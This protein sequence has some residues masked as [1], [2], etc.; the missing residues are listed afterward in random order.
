MPLLDDLKREIAGGPKP[1]IVCGAGV[2]KAAN[3]NAPNWRA[4]IDSGIERVVERRP[5]DAAWGARQRQALEGDASEWIGA[6]DQ[7]TDRL[8]GP[9]HGEFR[10]WLKDTLGD[11]VAER[12]E[13]L[14]A[15][16]EVARAGCL[17]STTNYDSILSK[18]LD[19]PVIHWADHPK[20]LEYLNGQRK[21]VL[22]LHGH[23]DEPETV[24]L[25][26]K[27]Y[28][29]QVR[30]ERRNFLQGMV[31]LTRPT[32]FVGC[33]ADGLNDP[34]FARLQDWLE[35]WDDSSP[36]R[37]WL[38]SRPVDAKTDWSLFPIAYGSHDK[39]PDFL[40]DLA[41]AKTST[42]PTTAGAAVGTL[43]PAAEP[44]VRC[45]DWEWPKPDA[46]GREDEIEKVARALVEGRPAVIA[47]GPGMGK[48]T[49]AVAAMYEPEVRARFGRR[50]VFATVEDAPEPRAFLAKLALALGLP[51]T[52]DEASLLRAIENACAV[53]PVAAILDNAETALDPDQSE[54]QRILRLLAQVPNLSLAVTMREIPVRLRADAE[55]L[56]DLAPLRLDAA[57]SAFLAVAGP[58]FEHDRFLDA[59]LESTL[60]G[61]ALSIRIVAA[62]AVGLPSLAGLQERWNEERGA[63]LRQEGA[64]KGR[65]TSVRASVALSLKS[66]RM[67]GQPLA[68]RLLALLA[69]LPAG[70]AENEVKDLL[71]EKGAV[72]KARAIE[73]A[74][75]L[76]QM[77]LVESRVEGR[78]RMLTP[79]RESARLHVPLHLPD[80]ERLLDRFLK[81]AEAGELVGTKDWPRVRE[82]VEAESGNL[83][84]VCDL[85]LRTGIQLSR[86]VR[87]LAGTGNLARLSG[88]GST[89][90]LSRSASDPRIQARPGL[91]AQIC[92]SIGV[93]ALGRSDYATAHERLEHA[94]G[95]VARRQ[96]DLETAWRRS[97][98]ALPLYRKLGNVIGEANSIRRMGGVASRRLDHD[99]A[100]QRFEEALPLF[101]K[102][103]DVLGEA[104]CIFLMT[105]LS[106]R[107]EPEARERFQDALQLYREVGDVLGEA[108]CI[109]DIGQIAL[110]RAD[111]SVARQ[112]FE[113]ALPLYRTIGNLFGEACALIRRG[114]LAQLSDNGAARAHFDEA[115]A[116]L[117]RDPKDLALPGWRAFHAALVTADS[118]TA[119]EK[120]EEAR[121]YW[122]RVGCLDLV[123]RFLDL[124]VVHGGTDSAAA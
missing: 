35:V 99:T 15:L 93:L 80:R 101:R 16:K 124:P 89:H 13:L 21:G 18:G 53:A 48:T 85:A 107:S 119:A 61:H 3:P 64:K 1:L 102:V 123:D 118:A 115:L 46:F 100:R 6:A 92:Y 94:L 69:Y 33:S 90:A 65:L 41:P 11:L 78:L 111:H 57:R 39:L 109:Y 37:Y 108:N 62:Q 8:G 60:E 81:L 72:S 22:H 20:V 56:G 91:M 10:R 49:V 2:S 44:E 113:D 7:I 73:A 55:V 82:A 54:G 79:L 59:L 25:G 95:E 98:E 43:L 66:P 28:D 87:A 5:A 26:T 71:G 36:R 110:S 88:L 86:V 17:V 29:R 103:G 106:W 105:E 51:A 121:A 104:N 4:L 63:I 23:W 97:E 75:R 116:V 32:L 96:S 27:S 30:D 34:D 47:G 117:E 74:D 50:R 45:I 70:L 76:R 19:L 58:E 31:S 52:G 24:I 38:V 14:D 114:Q 12:T 42:A 40:R 67:A 77:R 68:R 112:L 122:T 9:Q 84:S 83:D 120:R